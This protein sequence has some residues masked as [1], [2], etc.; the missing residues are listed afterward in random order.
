VIVLPGEH[1]FFLAGSD[2]VE[3]DAS[4]MSERLAQRDVQT[5]WVTPPYIRDLLTGDRFA[6]AQSRV[7]RESGVRIN[8]DLS[9]LSYYYSLA[10]WLARFYPGL[11]QPFEDAGPITV[12]WLVLPLVLCVLLARRKRG[13]AMLLVVAGV[14]LA[15]ML[16]E[17][18]L[19]FAYQ[20]RH[21]SLYGEVSLIITAFMA[22]LALG[23]ALGNRLSVA[24]A[25]KR[26]T[27]NVRRALA[28]TLA[29]MA[30]YSIVLPVLFS[31]P[32]RAE[33]IPHVV[34]LLLALLGALL[35]GIVFPLASRLAIA[36]SAPMGDQPSAISYSHPPSAARSTRLIWQAAAWVRCWVPRS[37]SRSLAFRQ[38]A[39][40]SRC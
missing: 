22:G 16:L 24:S 40:S 13:R 26:K 33:E 8:Q 32:L 3:I 38:R 23:G 34:F 4:L 7:K 12:W 1:N 18:V 29:M 27:Q 11:R 20:A 9:P 36:D 19:L 37:S 28:A 17:L 39:P 14:G 15:Q 6:E 10:H 5:R 31:V 25:V 2:P 35:G 21:G 30:V